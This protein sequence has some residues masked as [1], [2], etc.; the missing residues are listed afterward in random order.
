MMR[1]F[2]CLPLSRLMTVTTVP[3]GRDRWAAVSML[4]L[5]R[6]PLAVLLVIAYHDAM[7][8]WPDVPA[9]AVA[10]AAAAMEKANA[11]RDLAYIAREALVF[12]SFSDSIVSSPGDLPAAALSTRLKRNGKPARRDVQLQP[13]LT[14]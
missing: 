12:I 10:E 4:G 14:G 11:A 6:S 2:T 13:A 7:P 9:E 1:T 5:A 3:K 8:H